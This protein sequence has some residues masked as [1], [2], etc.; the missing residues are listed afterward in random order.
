MGQSDRCSILSPMLLLQLMDLHQ[1]T[2]LQLILLLCSEQI[3]VGNARKELQN[4]SLKAAKNLP[5]RVPIT[6]LRY[7][8]H[9]TQIQ[10]RNGGVPLVQLTSTSPNGPAQRILSLILEQRIR[11]GHEWWLEQLVT[12]V[13]TMKIFVQILVDFH[14]ES[15]VHEAGHRD[16]WKKT[17]VVEFLATRWRK[18]CLFT[19]FCCCFP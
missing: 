16:D 12:I 14:Q 8:S 9:V 18:Q 19:K 4:P 5:S 6:R 2:L 3:F 17:K 1:E 15:L 11:V 7:Q 13:E 10:W